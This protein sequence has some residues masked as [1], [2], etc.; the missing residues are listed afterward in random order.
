MLHRIRRFYLWGED[1]CGSIEGII[2]RL[3]KVGARIAY[4][5][6]RFG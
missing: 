4:P 1:T 5:E 2:I 6:L 3:L